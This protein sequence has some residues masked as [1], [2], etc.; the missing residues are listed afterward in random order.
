MNFDDSI[1]AEE[2]EVLYS[3]RLTLICYKYFETKYQHDKAAGIKD[4]DSE[5]HYAWALVRS[6]FEQDINLGL[7]ITHSILKTYSW[8]ICSR[9]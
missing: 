6:R 5:F 8:V 7:S 3:K 1:S 4:H 2:L 9:S